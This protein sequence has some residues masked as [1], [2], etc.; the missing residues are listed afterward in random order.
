[1]VKWV[2]SFFYT[3]FAV[4]YQRVHRTSSQ[5]KYSLLDKIYK[6]L[7][8]CLQ[9]AQQGY[10]YCKILHFTYFLTTYKMCLAEQVVNLL[11]AKLSIKILTAWIC[12]ML[13][14]NT[15]FCKML[16]MIEIC[17]I[18]GQGCGQLQNPTT[19]MTRKMSSFYNYDSWKN[20]IT[21]WI[22]GHR[23]VNNSFNYFS[24]F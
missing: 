11:T 9:A 5:Y 14:Q 7:S 17:Q 15:N 24:Q 6:N 3:T 12:V 21:I 19:I 8:Y 4:S 13:T 1:M 2:E 18:R 20:A 23:N 16:L 10:R 22:I